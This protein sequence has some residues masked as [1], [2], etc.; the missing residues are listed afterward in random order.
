MAGSYSG[1]GSC[2]LPVAESW[3]SCTG[4]YAAVAHRSYANY[5]TSGS[6]PCHMGPTYVPRGSR[7]VDAHLSR[8][9][10]RAPH[11]GG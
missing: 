11:P 9:R 5:Y 2:L 8:R 3:V 4:H 1:E 7:W 6:Q 10:A